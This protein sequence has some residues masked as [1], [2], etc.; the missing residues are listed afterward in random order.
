MR[1]LREINFFIFI[2]KKDEPETTNNRI[3]ADKHICFQ[4][5]NHFG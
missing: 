5:P 2:N 3:D 1:H 4:S